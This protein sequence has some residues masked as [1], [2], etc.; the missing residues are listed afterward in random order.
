MVARPKNDI[1]CCASD[2]EQFYY[3]YNP[4]RL[5]CQGGQGDGVVDLRDTRALASV[6]LR[7]DATVRI[8]DRL[9]PGNGIDLSP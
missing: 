1:G 8:L 3:L 9:H 5:V 2:P 4:T 6:A 7:G